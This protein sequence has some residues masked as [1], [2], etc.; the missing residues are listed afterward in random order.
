M[1]T[2]G[3]ETGHNRRHN[4]RGVGATTTTGPTR[5]FDG[6][7]GVNAILK[8]GRPASSDA[9]S[10]SRWA[11]SLNCSALALP[12]KLAEQQA[13][14]AVDRLPVLMGKIWEWVKHSDGSNG[15]PT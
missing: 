4:R 2:D 8:T 15:A 10:T 14:A 7:V 6:V 5:V 12:S 1:E 3:T 13:H 11:S 9:A